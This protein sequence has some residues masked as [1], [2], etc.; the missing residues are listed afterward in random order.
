MKCY[1]IL[2][3]VLIIVPTIFE[4]VIAGE[5]NLTILRF[6][7]IGRCLYGTMIVGGDNSSLNQVFDILNSILRLVYIIYYGLFLF[8]THKNK[9]KKV[10]ICRKIY[11]VLL[12]IQVIIFIRFV[13]FF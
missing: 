2:L 11:M 3:L 10:F 1:L 5:A 6:A 9:V 4:L 7:R 8:F 12:V 13:Y